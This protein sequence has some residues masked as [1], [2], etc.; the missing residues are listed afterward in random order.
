MESPSSPIFSSEIEV[1][2]WL[3]LRLAYQELNIEY[4]GD[5]G[6]EV[7]EHSEGTFVKTSDIIDLNHSKFSGSLWQA[8]VVKIW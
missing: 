8:N 6:F 4:N 5:K 7:P 2:S 3:L 1:E